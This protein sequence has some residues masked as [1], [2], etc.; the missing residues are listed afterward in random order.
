MRIF[1]VVLALV[2]ITVGRWLISR[3]EIVFGLTMCVAAGALLALA[4]HS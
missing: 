2:L 3:N 1:Y 4:Q